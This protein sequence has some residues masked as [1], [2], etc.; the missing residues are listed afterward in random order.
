MT[1]A[2]QPTT[3]NTRLLF[4]L[5]IPIV[6]VIQ[7]AVPFLA[8]PTLGQAVWTVGFGQSFLNQ[9]LMAIHA[10][11]MGAPEP[12]AIAFG[13]AGAYTTTLLLALGLEAP[14]A[15]ATM[16]AL[17]FT[18][19]YY[20][21]W[22]LSRYLGLSPNLA[23]L[24][25]LTWMSLPIIWNHASYSMLSMGIALL[26]TYIW[27][28]LNLAWHSRQSSPRRKPAIAL[29]L[30][31]CLISIFMD[32]YTFMM[33]ATATAAIYLATYWQNPSQ[34]RQI[35]FQLAPVIFLGLSLAYTL[36]ALYIGQSTY[37]RAPISFFRGWG[38]DLSFIAVPT[39]GV[40]WFWDALGLSIP[41]SAE[42]YFGDAS[43]WVTTFALPLVLTS[44]IALYPTLKHTRKIVT[45]LVLLAAIGYYMSL[46]P[47]LK[48]NSTKPHPT[49]DGGMQASHAIAPTANAVIS[50]YLPGFNNMR[51]SYRWSALGMLGS[52]AIVN[53]ALARTPMPR[54][55][56]ITLATLTFTL[57]ITSNLPHLQ[58]KWQSNHKNYQAF[59]QIQQTILVDLKLDTRPGEYVAF[60]PYRN[61]FLVNYLASAARIRA[62]NIGGDKNL[63][64]ARANWPMTL[65]QY[66]MAV[67]DEHFVSRTIT[68]L[69]ETTADTV[70]LP[71][72]DM[73]WAAHYWPY[74]TE[75][76]DAIEQILPQ[77]A[78]Y[79]GIHIQTR[80]YYTALRLQ[81]P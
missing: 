22:R 20:G 28:T 44:A 27:S 74:P 24:S 73:L 71:H 46:G 48:I 39:Q 29:Y 15:Y 72:I 67:I 5:T 2:A 3:S 19:A 61:D 51:A 63:A 54:A 26:P 75:H 36:F 65:R 42:T 11:N 25:A 33:F 9:S 21:A 18:I 45:I 10:T 23:I 37:E 6:L 43:V 62:Y 64:Q 14:N 30:A 38:L 66:P 47:S 57:L 12:A 76:R 68:L 79:P 55:K 80:E 34:R 13:L 56:R 58:R 7:G 60:L 53:L 49:P 52:W 41:R 8:I 69:T 78:S 17:W 1:T 32:G 16:A 50:R 4:L 70:V 40:H 81:T 59:Q 31:L 35:L 77:F